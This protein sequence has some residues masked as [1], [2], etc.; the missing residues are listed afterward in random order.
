[1][2][3]PLAEAA[4]TF[5]VGHIAITAAITA[6][7]AL[8]AAAWRLPRGMLIE[9]LAVAVLAFAAV[10]LWRLSANMPQLNNDGLPGFSANDWLAPV[11]TYITLSGYADLHAPADPRRFAQTR[12]L[13][14]IAALIVNVVTI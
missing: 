3:A 5:G 7:L 9:Q 14:T 6:V 13:A 8:A 11:L 4:G 1:M 12:A 10:L 2:N